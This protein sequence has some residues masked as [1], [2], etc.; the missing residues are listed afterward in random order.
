MG[1]KFA[2]KKNWTQNVHIQ[3]TL[4]FRYF[5]AFFRRKLTSLYDLKMTFS[6]NARNQPEIWVFFNELETA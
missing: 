4:L 2:K 3:L 1:Q 6:E 5:E